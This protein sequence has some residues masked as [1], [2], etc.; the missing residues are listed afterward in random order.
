M[1]QADWVSERLRSAHAALEVRIETFRTA[2]D[3][4]RATPLARLPGIGFFVKELERALLDRRI[5]LAVHCLK[6]VPT[7]VPEGLEVGAAVPEREDPRECLVT[8]T[9]LALSQLPPGAT[10]GTSSPRRRAMLLAARP[11]LNFTDLRGNVETRLSKLAAGVCH[12]TVL[13]RAGLAR[14]GVLDSRMMPLDTTVM[15]PAA[16]QGAL[17][18]ECRAD[19]VAVRRLL[20]PLDHPPTRW[21]VTAERSVVGHLGAGCRT[22]LG[23]LAAVSADGRLSLDAWLLSPHGSEAVRRT[24]GGDASQ[25]ADLGVVLAEDLLLAGAGRLLRPEDGGHDA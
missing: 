7:R 19:D 17:G 11:D 8:P 12:A 6:D 20:A 1:T 2:G 24:V 4:D 14:L 22:A 15:L 5:D 10:V 3:R 23:V 18:L 16:G 9:G 13:A 21:A 25:A